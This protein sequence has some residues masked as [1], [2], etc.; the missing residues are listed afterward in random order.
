MFGITEKIG[1]IK[2]YIFSDSYEKAIETSNE[3]HKEIREDYSGIIKLYNNLAEKGFIIE[4]LPL[5]INEAGH[6]CSKTLDSLVLLKK[7]IIKLK[8]NKIKNA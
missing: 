8:K 7:E 5:M 1:K 6:K 4:E 3:L 2:N